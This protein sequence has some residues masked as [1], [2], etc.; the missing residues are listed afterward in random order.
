MKNLEIKDDYERKLNNFMVHEVDKVKNLK[1][2]EFGVRKG[3]STKI[4]LNLCKTNNG[5]LY[6]VDVDDYSSLYKDENW[7]FI[8]TR[9]DDFKTIEENI[10]NEF[11]LIYLDSYHEPK[12]VE[13]IIRY[14]YPKLKTSGIYVIDDI[15]WL[16]YTKGNYRD[17]FGC[18]MANFDTFNQILDIY[19]NNIQNFDLDFTFVG[20]GLAKIFKKNDNEL[21]VSKKIPSRQFSF[22]NILKKIIK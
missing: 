8:H 3:I 12:H 18:E 22:K 13:K 9:D 21:N 4:F 14:Y 20:S 10:P 15:C 16:P 2:L 7:K 19:F 17:D 1:I 5:K 11:D 6:S